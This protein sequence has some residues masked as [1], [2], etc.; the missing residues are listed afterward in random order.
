MT[1]LFHRP[2]HQRE[3]QGQRSRHT[4]RRHTTR[5][6]LLIPIKRRTAPTLLRR[7]SRASASPPNRTIVRQRIVETKTTTAISTGLTTARGTLHGRQKGT[8]DYVL[9]ERMLMSSCSIIRCSGGRTL[10]IAVARLGQELSAFEIRQRKEHSPSGA[11]AVLP[12]AARTR[13]DSA[14]FV[15]KARCYT[16]RR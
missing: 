7:A 6:A 11:D 3:H 9:R 4:A 14:E 12:G 2:A 13:S 1:L 8:T 16:A 10:A 5:R 15:G